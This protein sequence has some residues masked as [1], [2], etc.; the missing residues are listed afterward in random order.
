MA[1][2]PMFRYRA[3]IAEV[4]SGGN[5]CW[6]AQCNFAQSAERNLLVLGR[7][8]RHS[9]PWLQHCISIHCTTIAN[10]NAHKVS[11]HSGT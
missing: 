1:S 5:L 2:L 10:P 11:Y 6:A 7:P 4:Q 3:I 9:P 8:T